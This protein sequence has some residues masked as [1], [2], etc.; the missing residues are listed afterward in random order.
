MNLCLLLLFSTNTF[1][2]L[3]AGKVEE[4][5]CDIERE[6]LLKEVITDGSHLVDTELIIRGGTM[7]ISATWMDTRSLSRL[8]L[9]VQQDQK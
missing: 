8:A 5:N 7:T 4:E 6:S 2:F 1:D 9:T 3:K